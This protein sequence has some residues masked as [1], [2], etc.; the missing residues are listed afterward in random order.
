MTKLEYVRRQTAHLLDRVLLVFDKALRMVP[1]GQLDFR[2][3][4]VSMSVR[5]LSVHTYQ[6]IYA[7]THAAATGAFQQADLDALPFDPARAERVEDIL[8]YGRQVRDYVRGAVAAMSEEDLTRMTKN[9]VGPP[10]APGYASMSMAYEEAL[11]HR[12]QLMLYLRMM[13]VAPPRPY[14]YR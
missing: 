6:A 4:P 10:S 9:E 2:P 1:P 8:A 3:T 12:G 13:G 11:H 5:E 14:D 7:L